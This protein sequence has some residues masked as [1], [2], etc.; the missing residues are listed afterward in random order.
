M[1]QSLNLRFS[2]SLSLTPQLKQSLKILQLS[3]LDLQQEIQ[4]AIETNPMLELVENDRATASL[5]SVVEEKS[6][7]TLNA[8]PDESR[9]TNW[10]EAF[11]S[12]RS[13]TISSRT[14]RSN[15]L[16]P[17]AIVGAEESLTE[18]LAWQIQMTTLSVR[19]K[20]IAETILHSIDEEG[21]LNSPPEEIAK[22]FDAQL[23]IETDEVQAVLSL[24]QTLEPIGV[25]ARDL[26][27][28]LSLL[29]NHADEEPEVKE[30]AKQIV[31]EHLD[32]L[33][34]R[35]LGQIKKELGIDEAQLSRAITAITKL[36]PRITNAYKSD[37]KDYI[38]PDLIVKKVDSEWRIE[39]NP[40]NQHRLRTNEMY[41]SLLNSKLDEEQSSY[42]HKNLAEAKALIK[43]LSS[44]YDTLLLVGKVILEKQLAFFEQGEEAMK[45]MILQDIA[46][47][48]ELHESTISRATS[49]KYLLSPRGVFELKFFFSSALNSV[50]G[51]SSSA[52]AIRSIIKKLITNESKTKPLSDSK[53]AKEL[54]QM[55]HVVARR[56][57]AKYRESM[58]IA[59]SSQRKSLV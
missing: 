49:G 46:E 7:L 42:L 13:S 43:S 50:S 4:E 41:T 39:V 5:D 47:Q 25:G 24:I 31:C 57:V 53:I 30:L 32:L 23:E 22:L 17:V 28:R 52:T 45:P 58:H 36:S 10:Q 3:S 59:S 27:E 33:G 9:D 14:E 26:S 38:T 51:E 35:N 19:D 21:Y 2:Q 44:R 48:L 8:V 18:H 12:K 34:N 11:E 29:L 15:D 56:T 1:K 6:E 55:G 20:L 54:E 16:E 40:D 37:N